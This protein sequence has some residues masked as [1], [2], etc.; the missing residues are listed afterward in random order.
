M[1]VHPGQ[2]EDV[3]AKVTLVHALLH[4]HG[5]DGLSKGEDDDRPGIVH[6]LDKDTSGLMI[7]CKTD[8]VHTKMKDLF[9]KRHDS[10]TKTYWALVLGKVTPATTSS[11][12]SNQLSLAAGA[13]A[14]SDSSSQQH[15][16]LKKEEETDMVTI[17]APMMRHPG[18]KQGHKMII[19]PAGDPKGKPAVTRYRVLKHW[20]LQKQQHFS[21]LEVNIETGRTHQIRVHLSSQAHPIVGDALYATKHNNHNVPY[22]LL[23]SKSLQF[24]HPITKEKLSFQVE[25]PPHFAKFVE[26]LDQQQESFEKSSHTHLKKGKKMNNPYETNIDDLQI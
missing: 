10:L 17:D 9:Q 6:R 19:A 15:H 24:E 25:L 23:T 21:L 8:D 2:G 26:K 12:T 13:H 11:S 18:S 22:L 20:T 5:R 3:D 1:A 14:S 7:V 4:R 16:H